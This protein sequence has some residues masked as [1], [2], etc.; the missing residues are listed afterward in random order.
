MHTYIK[1][2]LKRAGY[3]LLFFVSF[4]L[5]YLLSAFCLSRITVDKEED[6]NAEMVFFILTNGVHTDI[7]MP[8]KND[9]FDWSTQVKFTNT[10][11]ADT[12]GIQWLAT[13][14]GDKGFYLE[15]PT[16]NDLTFSTAFKAAFGLSSTAMHTVY[17]R[18]ITESKS[19]KKIMISKAQYKRLVQF[20]IDSFRLDDNGYPV[21]INTTANYNDA[22]AF[23][24]ATGSYSLFKTC[25]TWANAA[26]K[27]CGQ[28]ACLWTAFDTGI[29]LKYE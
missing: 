29:F 12:A 16:W 5:I 13:G 19:C 2:L 27:S 21:Y 18:T 24:E 25:N 17:Y 28:K 3:F 23:Y 9:V 11:L 6:P 4:V 10:H 26:L 22:D 14:W 1:K 15:T 20:V 7:V 8:V